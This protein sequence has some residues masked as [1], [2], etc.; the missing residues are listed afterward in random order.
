M[1]TGDNPDPVSL[2]SVHAYGDSTRQIHEAAAAAAQA[3][4]P[5]FVGEFGA[6]GPAEKSE[7]EF[8]ALLAAIEAAQV[9]LAALWVYDFRGQDGT[10]NVTANNDRASQLQAISAAN[11][12]LRAG[13]TRGGQTP[14]AAAPAAESRPGRSRRARGNLRPS[15]RGSRAAPG[16]CPSSST[17][18]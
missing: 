6:P 9:P 15:Y 1:L 5:L 3:R 16:R 14:P 10:W 7:K 12:R 18:E 2:L 8:R 17:G 4:K 13:L 11:A